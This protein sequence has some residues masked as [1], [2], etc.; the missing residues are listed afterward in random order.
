MPAPPSPIPPGTFD[1]P[2]IY[3]D[4][5]QTLGHHGG[6]INVTVTIGVVVPSKN[7]RTVMVPKI[8]AHLRCTA[9][10]AQQLRDAFDKALLLGAEAAGKPS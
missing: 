3:F 4:G 8:A 6:I 9:A 7:R 1:A 10:V 2:I 5:I